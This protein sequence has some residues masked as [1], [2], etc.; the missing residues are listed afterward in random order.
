LRISRPSRSYIGILGFLPEKDLVREQ[1][2]N[3]TWLEL[4]HI[5][6]MSSLFLQ[7]QEIHETSPLASAL[8]LSGITISSVTR[9]LILNKLK[10]RNK[11]P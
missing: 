8:H 3:Q 1:R 2:I 5:H 6:L 10:T 11:R 9:L 7:P 4:W